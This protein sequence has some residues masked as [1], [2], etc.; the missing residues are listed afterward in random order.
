MSDI[1]KSENLRQGGFRFREEFDLEG[2]IIFLLFIALILYQIYSGMRAMPLRESYSSLGRV[3]KKVEEVDRS[4]VILTLRDLKRYLAEGKK[5]LPKLSPPEDELKILREIYKRLAKAHSE[6]ELIR[7]SQMDLLGYWVMDQILVRMWCECELL[8]F[9]G[10]PCEMGEDY[11][12]SIFK[13]S[14]VREEIIDIA[15]CDVLY[16]LKRGEL[17]QVRVIARKEML[18]KA[19]SIAVILIYILTSLYVISKFNWRSLLRRIANK[20]VPS[21]LNPEEPPMIKEFAFA[22]LLQFSAV[23]LFFALISSFGILRG[24]GDLFSLNFFAILGASILSSLVVIPLFWSKLVPPWVNRRNF[25]RWVKV[26]ALRGLK[27]FLALSIFMIALEILINEFIMRGQLS[28]NPLIFFPLASGKMMWGLL[29]MVSVL[30][31]VYEEVT[32]RGLFYGALRKYLPSL[33]S[34]SLVGLTFAVIHPENPLAMLVLF[35]LGFILSLTFEYSGN[36]I[37]PITFH[38]L[39]NIFTFVMT[40]LR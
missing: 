13:E 25:F 28:S 27:L 11:S 21:V 19:L 34:A 6:L 18:S 24:E 38:S 32:F 23:L 22:Y 1:L 35:S 31:P 20:R 37:T 40:L 26:G 33:G 36:I 8:S 15:S 10:V 14:S 12:G 2:V 39:W 29:L 3:L 30:A 4:L 9:L 17:S 7:T 16:Y 5:E